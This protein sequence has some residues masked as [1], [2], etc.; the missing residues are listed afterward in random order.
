LRSPRG[1]PGRLLGHLMCLINRAPNAVAIAALGVGEHDHVLEIGFGPGCALRQ[2]ARIA[3]HGHVSGID[4]SPTMLHQA[5][6][7]NRQA[8][9][10]GA[11]ELHVARHDSLPLPDGSV[12]RILAVNVAYF[13]R[14]GSGQLN[15]MW[16][17]LKP[18]G[19]LVIYVTTETSMRNWKFASA[20]S[21]RLFGTESLG[22]LLA[23]ERLRDSM[24]RIES[25]RLPLG[26][27]AL[28]AIID[29]TES[30]GLS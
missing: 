17:V 15:D 28:L 18:G 3:C 25:I 8:I 10:A 30:A 5:R 13:F 21:H 19:R 14:E 27:D 7:R 20:K 4:P 24:S 12:D 1:V 29:K 6:A 23:C 2:L 9:Y 16:R 11:M 22:N 26:I